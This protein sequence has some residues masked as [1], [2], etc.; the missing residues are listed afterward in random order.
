M[1][2]ILKNSGKRLNLIALTKLNSNK[3]LLPEKGRLIKGRAVVATAMNDYFV[4]ITQTI[5][6]KQF[7]FHHAINL[8]EDH[9]SI[10]RI[11]CNLNNFSDKFDFKKVDEREIKREII[12]FNSKKTT[13]HCAILLKILKHICTSCLPIF[14]K[15]I[16]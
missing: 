13:C 1:S 11:K 15:I 2:V 14:T 4:N 3:T 10:I 12:N 8:F 9:A 7:H 6:L 5:G 16:N